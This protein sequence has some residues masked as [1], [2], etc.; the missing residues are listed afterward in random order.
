M[1]REEKIKYWIELSIEDLKA[2]ETLLQGGHYLYVG[3]M[4]HQAIEKIMK[5]Y[6]V[7]LIDEIPPFTHDLVMLASKGD[8]YSSFTE[9]QK[10][11]IRQLNPLHIKARYPEYKD[12]IYRQLTKEVC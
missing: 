5:G 11:F 12:R 2:G 4:C 10:D 1:T 3:F 9:N 7:K 6:F 8:F